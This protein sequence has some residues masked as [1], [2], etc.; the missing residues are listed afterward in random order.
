MI[1]QEQVSHDV[2]HIYRPIIN[3]HINVKIDFGRILISQV[4]YQ[5]IR[6]FIQYIKS[7]FIVLLKI[8]VKLI[9]ENLKNYV[10]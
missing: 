8:V 3:K 5:N 9:D 4:S 10:A 1:W 7:K 2:V 6:V